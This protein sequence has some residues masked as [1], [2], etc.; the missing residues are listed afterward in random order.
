MALKQFVIVLIGCVFI[1]LRGSQA[2]ELEILSGNIG[3]WQILEN[4]VSRYY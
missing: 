1:G 3:I 4:T 2:F